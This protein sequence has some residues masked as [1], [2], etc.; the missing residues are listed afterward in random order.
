[1]ADALF[2]LLRRLG[3]GLSDLVILLERVNAL[4]L[5]R[6]AFVDVVL[7]AGKVTASAPH[8]L[9]APHRGGIL[10]T[11]TSPE[12]VVVMLPAVD[13]TSVT[14]LASAAPTVDVTYRLW[15]F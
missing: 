8:G 7:E 4:P 2:D 11:A 1:M 6:G 10:L 9:F 13:T 5:L 12:V 15:V 3:L 14:V